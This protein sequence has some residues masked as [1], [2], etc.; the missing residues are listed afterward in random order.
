MHVHGRAI[1]LLPGRSGLKVPAGAK[2]F[3][4]LP[5]V[6]TSSEAELA[7]Y[8]VVTKVVRKVKNVFPYKDIY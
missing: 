6:Q 2:D 4:L 1:G 3:S 7:T 8:L 5:N